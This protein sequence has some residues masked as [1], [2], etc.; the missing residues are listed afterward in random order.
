MYSIQG[1]ECGVSNDRVI[2]SRTWD[3]NELLNRD[4][5]HLTSELNLSVPNR[6]HF[7]LSLSHIPPFFIAH[8]DLL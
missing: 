1:F 2:V 7:I 8:S 5:Y 4:P 3:D 6:L